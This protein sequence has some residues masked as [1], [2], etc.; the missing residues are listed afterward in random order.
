MGFTSWK[1]TLF[2]IEAINK[3]GFGWITFSIFI[4]FFLD[5]GRRRGKK[6]RQTYK[7]NSERLEID[8]FCCWMDPLFSLSSHFW[9]RGE[10]KGARLR[11]KFKTAPNTYRP[12]YSCNRKS[13]WRGGS[14]RDAISTTPRVF[15]AHSGDAIPRRNETPRFQEHF[16]RGPVALC[17]GV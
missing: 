6:T 8:H 7:F 3:F 4:L 15:L 10:P 13:C 5:G 11:W 17:A 1:L 16:N 12:L 14:N 2:W 9:S